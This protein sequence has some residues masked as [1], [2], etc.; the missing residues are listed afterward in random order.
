MIWRLGVGL[1]VL[2]LLVVI[3]LAWSRG[4]DS[5]YY[6]LLSMAV[7]PVSERLVASGQSVPRPFRPDL[8]ADL[9]AAGWQP[10]Q[11]EL[12]D[13]DYRDGSLVMAPTRESVWWINQR[14]PMLYRHL[15]GD[16]AIT[17]TVRARK[18]SDVE[19]APDMEWQFG[20]ILLR[21]PRGDAFM[22]RE[23]YVFNVI[24]HRGSRLQVETKSTHKG[25]SRV[26]A[27]DWPSGDA[28]LRIERRGAQF[29]MAARATPVDEW[30]TLISYERADLPAQLQLGLIVYAY[31]E[32]RGRHDL[33]V[34][35]DRLEVQ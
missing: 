16:A 10:F 19:A 33:Q 14:G 25:A 12:A 22:S 6:K 24:G 5:R 13:V 23:N 21:D 7:M 35:F 8:G 11:L 29:T 20:G 1:L 3:A 15:D 30:R 31:S 26:D 18:R 2:I 34:I 17:V 4:R 28:E 9:L 32:G 27:W